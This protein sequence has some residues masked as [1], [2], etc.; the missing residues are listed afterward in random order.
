MDVAHPKLRR[1]L[2][3]TAAAYLLLGAGFATQWMFLGFGLHGW[4]GR[5]L[6][7]G[8]AP[9]FLAFRKLHLAHRTEAVLYALKRGLVALDDISF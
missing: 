9:S 5:D 7:E 4:P 8:L 3:A 2:D 6:P 1:L